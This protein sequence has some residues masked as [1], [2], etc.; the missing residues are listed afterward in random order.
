M[1]GRRLFSGMRAFG[2]AVA[3]LAL[4][5]GCLSSLTR[6]PY[7]TDATTTFEVLNFATADANSAPVVTYGASPQ[8][9]GASTTAALVAPITVASRTDYQWTAQLTGLVPTTTYCYRL[10]Q[11][12]S[13][14]L[15]GQTPSFTTPPTVGSST[16]FSFAV[17]GD[18]GAGTTDETKVLSQMRAANPN[19]AVTVGDNAYDAGTQSDYGDI[20]GG[21]VFTSSNWPVGQGTPFFLAHGNHGFDQ[22]QPYLQN[23]PEAK[24]T[25]LSGGRLQQDTYCCLGVMPQSNTFASA[26][27]AFD[28][29]NARFYVLEAAFSDSVSSAY[30]GDFQA[31]WAGSVPGCSVCGTE[32]QW[33]K[34][35]LAAHASTPLKFAF[36]HYPL[37]AEVSGEGGDAYLTG[38]N[39]LEG[40]LAN[41]GVKI[42]FN[43]H[44]HIYERN[45]PQI[46]GTPMVNYV[47]GT[48][49]NWLGTITSCS[50]FDAYALG[51]G[52]SCHAPVPTS[53]S[54]VYSFLRVSVNGTT[55]TVT[56]TDENG[57]PFDQQTYN[58]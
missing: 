15:N 13:D 48:G 18:F 33:L 26:W 7:L 43:G 1:L 5:A 40:T 36:F 19:F 23:F 14:P 41:N 56:P 11:N 17:F 32:L 47:T 16:P 55:V 53:D 6:N 58:F 37:R 46:S 29:G 2:A 39:A 20:T 42:A 8:C 9:S 22:F 12:G 45:T 44:A 30:Q 21:N 3:V 10:S 34:A 50:S 51:T 25:Q 31:H 52:S 35:D 28:W 4:A 54:K 24:V 49:G 27:Y 57:N 38:P